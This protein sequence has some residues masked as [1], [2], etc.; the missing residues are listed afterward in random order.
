VAALGVGIGFGLQEIVANF[1]SGLIILFERPIRVGDVVTIGDRDGTVTKI[2]IRATTLRDWDGKELLV[3]NKE[4]I[5]G[6]LLNWTL[7]DPQTRLVIPVGIAY[8][9]NVELALRILMDVVSN[10]PAVL[11]D[12]E[13]SVLF[14]GFGDSSLN[15][16]AR[17]FV[18][19]MDQRMPTTSDL[20]RAIDNAFKEA[21]IVIAFPQR[22][23]HLDAVQPIR[24]AIEH[25][26]E[27]S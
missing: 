3:P 11:E 9:S 25:P 14:L 5:T 23:M 20:H 7:S 19:R 26:E 18:G 6:R 1:I 10:H 15:L 12:P 21:G 16:V 13:P 2:R 4:F 22:D 24:V 8:G 27:P 17:C